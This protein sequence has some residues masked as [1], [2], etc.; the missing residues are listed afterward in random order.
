MSLMEKF[1]I[2]AGKP[3]VR[4]FVAGGTMEDAFRVAEKLNKEGF[5]AII[6]FLGEEVKDRTQVWDNIN[7]YAAVIRGIRHQKLV[8]ISV[9]PSQLGLKIAPEFYRQ[10]LRWLGRDAFLND[11]T[12]EIDIETEDTAEK[13]IQETIELVNYFPGINLRQSL[14]MNFEMSFC[15]LSDL[16]AAKIP[17]RLYKGAYT[18]KFS[19]GKLKERYYS[20]ASFLLRQ[21]ANPDF[22]T[23]DFKLLKRI[24]DLRSAYPASCGFQFLLGLRKRTWKKLREK[25]ERVAIYVPFGTHWLPYW[26]YVIKKIP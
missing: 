25:N 8:R 4:R 5:E 14:A 22:A 24:F 19:G 17:V 10:H 1:L 11:I 23:Y 6:N 12:L 18:S 15:W 26:K 16:A 7:V 20:A 3:F 2:N 21:D 9:K 13:A